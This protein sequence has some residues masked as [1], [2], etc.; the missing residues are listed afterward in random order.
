MD[1]QR[2][3]QGFGLQVCKKSWEDN[4]RFK[5]S[6][7]GPAIHDVSLNIHQKNGSTEEA[8]FLRYSNRDDPTIEGFSLKDIPLL[9]GNEKTEPETNLY[10][11]TLEEYLSNFRAFQTNPE[12][13]N[14]RY[15]SFLLPEE[16]P[17][18]SAQTCILPVSKDEPTKFSINVRSYN[19][20]P[21]QPDTL[22]IISHPKY[23]TTAQILLVNSEAGQTL[24]FNNGGQRSLFQ[25]QPLNPS[26]STPREDSEWDDS[27]LLVIFVPIKSDYMYDSNLRSTLHEPRNQKAFLELSKPEGPFRGFDASILER[28]PSHP[29]RIVFQ[30]YI[31]A[32]QGQLFPQDVIDTVNF[33]QNVQTKHGKIFP[34]SYFERTWTEYRPHCLHPCF[35]ETFK[36]N[37]KLFR[38]TDNQEI[39]PSEVCWIHHLFSF[40]FTG[41]ELL[42][43]R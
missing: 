34:P 30:R 15:E 33:F 3:L 20:S 43:N 28:N 27:N 13:I 32:N 41:L 8:K 25:V 4:A 12:K 37:V 10:V 16:K 23:G 29:I 42:Q 5:G 6:V 31:Q 17:I 22:V 40:L 9:V 21:F 14:L 36:I 7:W 39:H 35:E 18:A 24:Y 19:T 26:G 2:L 1:V 38:K 11:V